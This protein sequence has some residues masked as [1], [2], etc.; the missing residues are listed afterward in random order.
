MH[1]CGMCKYALNKKESCINKSQQTPQKTNIFYSWFFKLF[2]GNHG[3]KQ[4][5]AVHH[6][7]PSQLICSSS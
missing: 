3:F 1:K 7:D 4:F 5:F 2:A 6:I